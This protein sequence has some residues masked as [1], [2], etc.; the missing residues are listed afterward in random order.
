MSYSLVYDQLSNK[1]TRRIE[2]VEFE[3][4][5]V[6]RH[7][8]GSKHGNEAGFLFFRSNVSGKFS[9]GVDAVNPFKHLRNRGMELAHAHA[10]ERACD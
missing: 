10:D 4:Y 9:L 2:V 7:R 3:S 5:S 6:G 8:L 1:S